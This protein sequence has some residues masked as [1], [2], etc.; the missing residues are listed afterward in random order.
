MEPKRHLLV[1]E[2]QNEA[3]KHS[4][5][6]TPEMAEGLRKKYPLTGKALRDSNPYKPSK[7]SVLTIPEE[8]E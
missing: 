7:N 3:L 6:I 5:G 1:P 2:G 4:L 8:P